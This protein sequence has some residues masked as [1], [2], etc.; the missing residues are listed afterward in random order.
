MKQPDQQILSFIKTQSRNKIVIYKKDLSG[1]KSLD[2][3]H[4][5]ADTIQNIPL[6]KHYTLKVKNELNKILDTSISISTYGNILAI[7][8]L[9]ILFEP[10]LKIDFLNLIDNYSKNNT[11]FIHWD[12]DI[13]NNK[14][15]FLSKSKGIEININNLSHI[16]LKDEI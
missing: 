10:D 6:K 15:F 13:E 5:L 12:G 16:I 11:L 14:L 3:G 9:G 1:I 7:H 4:E 8:N 2:L